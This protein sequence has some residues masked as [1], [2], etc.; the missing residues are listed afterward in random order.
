MNCPFCQNL[1]IEIEK[2]VN[3][4][5]YW[6]GECTY[7][8]ILDQDNEGNLLRYHINLPNDYS[9]RVSYKTQTVRIYF[10]KDFHGITSAL[11]TINHVIP[12]ITP[13]NAKEKLKTYLTFL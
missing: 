8:T 11:V 3:Y 7:P 4:T 10:Q 13:D 6:C 5:R 1:A 12:N 9:I 2:R